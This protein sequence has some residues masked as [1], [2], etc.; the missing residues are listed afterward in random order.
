MELIDIRPIVEFY[1]SKLAQ[2]TLDY[3]RYLYSQINWESRVIGIKGER[4]VGKTT[5]LLQRIKEKYS[6]PDETFY[7][8]LDHYWFGTHPLQDLIAFL[9]KRGITEFYIDE[10]HKYKGWSAI[11]KNL[12]DQYDDLRI[13]YTGSSL[14][15][16]DNAKVDMSRRQT[17]YTLKGMSFREYLAY[18]GI[19]HRDA[20]SLEELLRNHV[21]ISFDVISKTKILAAFEAYLRTGIY[22]FHRDAGLD[23]LVRLKEVVDTVIESDLPAVEKVTYDTLEKCKKLL[24]IIAENV[25]LQPNVSRLSS[26]LGT[27]RDS[28]LKL[29]YNLDK[30]EILELL[31][32]ELKSYKKLVNPEK[33]YLGN[34]NLMYAL[35][36]KIDV[37]TLRETFFIDQLSAIGTVQM[38]L[39]GDFLV[40]GKYLFEVGGESKEFD[41]IAGIPDSYL[42]IAGI[43]TGYSARIPLWMF[44]FLY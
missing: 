23:F 28:L 5:M 1:H 33:I 30:A 42:A 32:V 27:T 29:L 17:S 36:P 3:K 24:M 2:I 26:S 37:G 14:L 21:P 40:N 34:T 9:Y 7:I 25:P 6:N 11:L 31:T 35:S 12:V 19:L 38:P 44:G 41:Q 16:I 18:E 4:G 15:E 39:K 43:E 8:S 13:V 22:P 10:V 20:V